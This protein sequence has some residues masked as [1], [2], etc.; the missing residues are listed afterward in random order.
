MSKS[1]LIAITGD[2][3]EGNTLVETFRLLHSILMFASATAM[4]YIT[5]NK[6]YALILT[7]ND[8]MYDASL[9]INHGKLFNFNNCTFIFMESNE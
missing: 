1:I 2:T 5:F 9:N 4:A 7:L 8:I 3:N 6:K